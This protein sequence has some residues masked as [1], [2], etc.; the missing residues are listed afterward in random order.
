MTLRAIVRDTTTA[1]RA[2]WGVASSGPMPRW[3][4]W[5]ESADIARDRADRH[6][7]GEDELEQAITRVLHARA[8]LDRPLD[9]LPWDRMRVPHSRRLFAALVSFIDDYPGPFA[10]ELFPADE[11]RTLRAALDA[12]ARPLTIDEQLAIAL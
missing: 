2:T 5:M 4:E 11:A 8:I 1:V 10:R 7:A 6:N 3:R 12:R 9:G